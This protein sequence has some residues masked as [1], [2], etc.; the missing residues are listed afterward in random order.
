[1][2]NQIEHILSF[3]IAFKIVTSLVA[4]FTKYIC[5]NLITFLLLDMI[6]VVKND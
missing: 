2:I 1:M 5:V 4:L 6:G 3:Y